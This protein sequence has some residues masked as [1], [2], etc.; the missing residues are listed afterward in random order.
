MTKIRDFFNNSKVGKCFQWL[1]ALIFPL[2]LIIILEFA[3]SRGT[4]HYLNY[5]QNKIPLI[6]FLYVFLGIIIF[7]FAL[8]VKKFW[9]SAVTFGSILLISVFVNVIK[10]NIT[11]YPFFPWDVLLIKNLGEITGF[12]EG[13]LKIPP[14][15]IIGAIAIILYFVLLFMS[16]LRFKFRKV[17]FIPFC[18]VVLSCGLFFTSSYIKDKFLPKLGLTG[19]ML[20]YQDVNYFKENGFLGSFLQNCCNMKLD[21]TNQYDSRLGELY[22]K[23]KIDDD[24]ISQMK[25]IDYK[26]NI[27]CILS[28]S[29]C[30]LRQI[31]GLELSEDIYAPFDE[32]A[33]NGIYGNISVPVNGGGTSRTE[34]QFLSGLS[35]DISFEGALPYQQFVKNEVPT[36]ASYVKTL[37]YKTVGIHPYMKKFYQRE[38]VYPLLGFDEFIGIEDLEDRSDF[39]KEDEYVTD[40][41]FTNLAIEQLKETEKNDEPLFLFGITM[42][43]HYPYHENKFKSFSDSVKVLNTDISDKTKDCFESYSSGVK[44]SV[45]ALKRLY[46]YI[47]ASDRPTI[48]VFFGDHLPVIDGS[49]EYFKEFRLSNETADRYNEFFQSSY[50]VYTNDAERQVKKHRNTSIA[51]L[52]CDIMDLASFPKFHVYKFLDDMRNS[53]I[54]FI[55]GKV[56]LDKDGNYYF[57]D[58]NNQWFVDHKIITYNILRG[59]EFTSNFNE[60]KKALGEK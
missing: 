17:N 45:I 4:E 40:D 54:E 16:D 2:A 13:N 52:G 12:A 20:K 57:N 14:K 44:E 39:V 21:K 43:N 41:Y 55:N 11:S 37:G 5:L 33:S 18:A 23:Y 59:K 56:M 30:D 32:M 6:L 36:L 31:D 35:V 51:M 60:L 25:N 8:L 1:L 38:K 49:G 28:E 15:L 26:P 27:I 10:F 24:I 3:N 29:F 50:F 42:Q 19:E 48:L 58:S 46:D 34:F 47:N 22:E 7:S 9:I 53:D